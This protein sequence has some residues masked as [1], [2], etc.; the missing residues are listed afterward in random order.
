MLLA[1]LCE[2]ESIAHGVLYLRR[3]L[4]QV[5]QRGAHQMTGFGSSLTLS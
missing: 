5:I 4:P 1:D 2:I 3:K